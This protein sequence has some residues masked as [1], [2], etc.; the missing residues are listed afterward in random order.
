MGIREEILQ[1]FVMAFSPLPFIKNNATK[2]N[3]AN[4]KGICQIT[5]H[6][7]RGMRQ[8]AT[9]VPVSVPRKDSWNQHEAAADLCNLRQSGTAVN[10]G[11]VATGYTLLVSDF[12]GNAI[13]IFL[14]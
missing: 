13:H 1:D 2:K 6:K 14:K 12:L 4:F 7:P 10:E 3:Q 11:S 5:F 8:L 9:T